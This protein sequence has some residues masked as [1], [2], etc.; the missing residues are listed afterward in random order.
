M[1]HLFL[2]TWLRGPACGKMTL[3]G[4]KKWHSCMHAHVTAWSESGL[5]PPDC[6]VPCGQVSHLLRFPPSSLETEIVLVRHRAARPKA[7]ISTPRSEER[8]VRRDLWGAMNKDREER[9]TRP[10]I[11]DAADWSDASQHHR[12]FI[13]EWRRITDYTQVYHSQVVYLI[14]WF[15][16]WLQICVNEQ[17]QDHKPVSSITRKIFLFMS[18]ILI[19]DA[20]RVRKSSLSVSK[21]H[22]R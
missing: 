4:L 8:G 15:A 1:L 19:M 10:L 14:F 13:S 22:K 7:L 20:I 17:Q 16:I 18:I 3:K 12:S 9:L 21:K 6:L 5:V 11:T 2:L